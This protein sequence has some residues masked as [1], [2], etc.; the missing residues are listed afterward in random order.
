MGTKQQ[1]H[2]AVTVYC[3]CVVYCAYPVTLQERVFV[4]D[5]FFEWQKKN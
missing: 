4:H 2:I 1:P 3:M 5:S